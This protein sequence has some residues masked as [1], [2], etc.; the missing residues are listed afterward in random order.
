LS[1]RR[2]VGGAIPD[3]RRAIKSHAGAVHS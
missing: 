2:S 1:R 3:V